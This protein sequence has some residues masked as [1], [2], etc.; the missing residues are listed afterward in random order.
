MKQTQPNYRISV[1]CVHDELTFDNGPDNNVWSNNARPWVALA[2][3]AFYGTGTCMSCALGA[4]GT[5]INFM[6]LVVRRK[7]TAGMESRECSESKISS[8]NFYTSRSVNCFDAVQCTWRRNNTQQTNGGSIVR[9][10][11]LGPNNVGTRPCRSEIRASSN[12]YLL[13]YVYYCM[14]YNFHSCSSETCTFSIKIRN[15][16][17]FKLNKCM[18]HVWHSWRMIPSDWRDRHRI[19]TCDLVRLFS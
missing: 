7:D 19:D 16:I 12:T 18:K 15:L 2:L 4:T 9:V 6:D 17:Y 14:D 5:E 3:F 11:V 1:V 8:P 10:C 13:T